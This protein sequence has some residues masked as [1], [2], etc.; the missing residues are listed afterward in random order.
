MTAK[1]N[2]MTLKLWMFQ[3]LDPE[4]WLVQE[5]LDT[6]LDIGHSRYLAIL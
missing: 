4:E 5:I 1:Q 3:M 2:G 6:E